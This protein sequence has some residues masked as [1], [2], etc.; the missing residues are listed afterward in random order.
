MEQKQK[1]WNLQKEYVLIVAIFLFVF[2]VFFS[3]LMYGVQQ[4]VGVATGRIVE[5]DSS[6]GN[7]GSWVLSIVGLTVIVGLTMSLLSYTGR[8]RTRSKMARGSSEVYSYIAKTRGLGFKDQEVKAMMFDGG[9]APEQIDNI[10][11]ELKR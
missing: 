5:G 1:I 9:W 2:V 3:F 6:S 4:N 11:S 8:Q 7:L 10:F